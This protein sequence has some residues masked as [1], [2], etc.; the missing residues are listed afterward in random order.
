MLKNTKLLP[1]LFLGIQPVCA[2]VGVNTN[3]PQS[4]LHIHG[5]LQLNNSLFVGGT[6]DTKGSAG[7][8]GDILYSNNQGNAPIWTDPSKIVV[9][10]EFLFL[11]R[12]TASSEISANSNPTIYF[13]QNVINNSLV[14]LN[15]TTQPSEFTIK[16]KGKYHVTVYVRYEITASETSGTATTTLNKDNNIISGQTTGHANNSKYI[17][18][19]FSY[20]DSFNANEKLKV[21]V[22]YTKYFK[23]VGGS[24]SIQYIGE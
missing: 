7:R 20:S 16:T 6:A 22:D 17:D 15:S 11:K 13:N 2:Q 18:H 5:D 19:N 23:I 4:T 10:K 8:A 14:E 21:N 1:F 3:T 12:T 9:P 24:F